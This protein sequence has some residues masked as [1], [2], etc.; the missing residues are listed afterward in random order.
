VD[1]PRL[2][3]R[4]ELFR[5]HVK[6]LQDYRPRPY[7]GPVTLFRAAVSEP[8]MSGGW[9]A[10]VGAEPY[11]LEGDHY[12]LLRKPALDCLV[13]H[14]RRDLAMSLRVEVAP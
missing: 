4:F 6:A 1:T 5:R 3:A 13:E 10:L 11:V 7:G 8:A 2:R 12:A 14:L 9:S